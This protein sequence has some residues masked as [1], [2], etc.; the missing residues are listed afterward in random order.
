MPGLQQGTA[1]GGGALHTS[2]APRL[3]LPASSEPRDPHR[4]LA[5]YPEWPGRGPSRKQKRHLAPA[6]P[7]PEFRASTLLPSRR[8]EPFTT[9][10]IRTIRGFRGPFPAGM[11]AWES[12]GCSRGVQGAPPRH[13]PAY[14]SSS[15]RCGGFRGGRPR[16]PRRRGN[17]DPAAPAH[18]D[19]PRPALPHPTDQPVSLPAF[20][21]RLNPHPVGPAPGRP[22]APSPHRC[23]RRCLNLRSARRRARVRRPAPPLPMPSP[24]V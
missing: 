1:E 19:R 14:S 10:L 5:D 2:A 17:G 12:P 24:P 20:A 18:L 13:H 21:A 9:G 3:H 6:P 7:L 11:R 16:C 22:P 4:P 15:G 8:L 23:R